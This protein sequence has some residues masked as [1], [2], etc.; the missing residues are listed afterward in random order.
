[1]VVATARLLVEPVVLA[2]AVVKTGQQQVAR[3]QLTKAMQVV[4]VTAVAVVLEQLDIADLAQAQVHQQVELAVQELLLQ[5][6]VHQL[7]TLQVV[8]LIILLLVQ[9]SVHQILL[10]VAAVAQLPTV[11]FQTQAAAVL[12]ITAT[13]VQVL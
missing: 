5:L 4:L 10:L 9:Q 11:V 1:V 3:E 7:L 13:A 2:A 12:Q 6:A 8:L